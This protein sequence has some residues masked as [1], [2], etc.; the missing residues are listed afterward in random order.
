MDHRAPGDREAS[1]H[2]DSAAIRPSFA[3]LMGQADNVGAGTVL[4]GSQSMTLSVATPNDLLGALGWLGFLVAIV[5][6]GS[7]T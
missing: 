1:L 5:I 3:R 2:R 7:A 4:A 6:A